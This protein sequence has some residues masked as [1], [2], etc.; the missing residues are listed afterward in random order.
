M[1][2]SE[3][4]G[5][6][7]ASSSQLLVRGLRVLEQVA[8]HPNPVGVGEL[9]REASLPKST[10]QRILGTLAELGW[11]EA[12]EDPVTR[13]RLTDRL[14]TLSRRVPKQFDL[15]QAALPHMRALHAKTQEQLFLTVPDLQNGTTV[16]IEKLDCTLPVRV[17]TPLGNV[18][19]MRASANGKAVLAALSD[20][21][22]ERIL[23]LDVD[24][25]RASA[26]LDLGELRRQIEEIRECGY[27]V[28]RGEW[29]T[30]VSA[31]AAAVLDDNAVPIAALV[32]SMPSF[33]F[34]EELVPS[35]GAML[36]EATQAISREFS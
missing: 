4:D 24:Y 19:P 22:V 2:D 20:A 31:V 11:I 25:R 23:E 15:R 8:S 3:S 10:V 5:T 6:I 28:G 9:A 29:R 7:G 12:I 34:S 17:Y 13:W 1:S 27:A 30:G 36:T 33:R 16:L 26:P 18:T 21:E 35:C 32:L 14:F